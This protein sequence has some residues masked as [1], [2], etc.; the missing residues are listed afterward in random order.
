MTEE[1]QQSPKKDEAR[2]GVVTGFALAAAALVCQWLLHLAVP[3][4][5]FAPFSIGEFVV[6]HA[7]GGWPP[8]LSILSVYSCEKNTL[9]TSV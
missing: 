6:R 3:A 9:F 7:P 8:G 5:P 1:R 4:A 2:P